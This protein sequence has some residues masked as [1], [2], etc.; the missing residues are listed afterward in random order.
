[1][2]FT[3]FSHF[4]PLTFGMS[5]PEAIALLG[6][7]ESQ[8]NRYDLLSMY[9]DED[10]MGAA[11]VAN[12]KRCEQLSWP[13]SATTNERPE[14]GF[15]DGVMAEIHLQHKKDRLMIGGVNVFA[16]NRAAVAL[17]LAKNEEVMLMSG[18][19]Y[20]FE[21]IGVRMTVRSDWKSSGSVGLLSKFGMEMT[22]KLDEFF[23]YAPEEI[24]G[25]E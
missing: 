16:T 9:L 22:F 11:Y 10:V 3:P 13:D 8:Q 5:I 19:D 23:E 15:V 6:P 25:R 2:D 17:D 1:M 14:L 21:S 12:L 4:G 20:L 7:P 18:A 24:T